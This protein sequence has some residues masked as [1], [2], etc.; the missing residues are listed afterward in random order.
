MTRVRIGTSRIHWQGLFAAQAIRKGTRII[1]YTGKRFPGKRVSGVYSRAMPISSSSMSAMRLTARHSRTWPAIS[2]IPVRRIV[3][4]ISSE[5][6]SGLLP[7]GIFR[8]V[9]N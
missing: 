4:Q 6:I 9:R 2:T 1:E 7:S 3:P 8:M 5:D